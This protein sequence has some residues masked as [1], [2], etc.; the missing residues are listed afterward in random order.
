MIYSSRHINLIYFTFSPSHAIAIICGGF[1]VEEIIKMSASSF[2]NVYR[3]ACF[4]KTQP[5]REPQVKQKAKNSLQWTFHHLKKSF[6][7]VNLHAH[8]QNADLH[9]KCQLCRPECS[10]TR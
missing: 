5:K 8:T 1:L 10:E 9:N 7:C 2:Y 3:I 4:N 6:H